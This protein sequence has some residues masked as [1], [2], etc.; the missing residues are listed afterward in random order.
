[1]NGEMNAQMDGLWLMVAVVV[2]AVGSGMLVYGIRQRDALT[3]VFG[4]ALN[5]IPIFVSAGALAALLTLALGVLFVVLR[6][7]R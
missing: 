1:M 3:L 7:Y 2:G 4:V 5:V 6:K